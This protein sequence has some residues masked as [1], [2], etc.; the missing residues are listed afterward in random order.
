MSAKKISITQKLLIA[1]IWANGNSATRSQM[2]EWGFRLNTIRSL[3]LGDNPVLQRDW[4][5][6]DPMTDQ[7]NPYYTETAIAAYA[8]AVAEGYIKREVDKALEEVDELI[9]ICREQLDAEKAAQAAAP[10]VT[11]TTPASDSEAAEILSAPRTVSMWEISYRHTSGSK[12]INWASDI[13]GV[14]ENNRQMRALGQ[15]PMRVRRV[16]LQYARSCLAWLR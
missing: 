15:T 7:I 13:N 2:R 14:I 12:S 8:W 3:V 5:A 4:L 16:A 10:E 9:V 1:R 6:D 11:E